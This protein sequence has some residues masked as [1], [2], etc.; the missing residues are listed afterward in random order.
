[1]SKKDREAL[2]DLSAYMTAQF[3][4]RL[5]MNPPIPQTFEVEVFRIVTQKKRY[6]VTAI[7]PED[8][9]EIANTMAMQDKFY[10]ETPFISDI[11]K[12]NKDGSSD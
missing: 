1:M 8:A 5:P 9:I 11:I 10:D 3:Y 2:R 4:K 7:Y 6:K 12:E